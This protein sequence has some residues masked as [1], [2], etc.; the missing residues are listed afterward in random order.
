MSRRL[1]PK[2]LPRMHSRW[3]LTRWRRRRWRP[4]RRRRRS[5]RRARAML[6]RRP[7]AWCLLPW[8]LP[9]RSRARRP[10]QPSRQ[11]LLRQ[12]RL[13]CGARHAAP[14]GRAGGHAAASVCRAGCVPS[15]LTAA[16]QRGRQ[17]Q[18]PDRRTCIWSARLPQALPL[19]GGKEAS[20]KR[21]V[22]LAG[23]EASAPPTPARLRDAAASKAPAAAAAA[24]A[25]KVRR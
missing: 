5:R 17:G 8:C 3:W 23:S 15:S 6:R 14:A 2:S 22:S 4:S 25:G 13:R 12:R 16:L 10:S 9:P 19:A 21:T 20:L 1:P 24:V 18:H 7:L 11:R